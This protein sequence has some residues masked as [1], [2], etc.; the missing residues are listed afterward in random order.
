MVRAVTGTFDK[1]EPEPH[2]SGPAPKHWIRL[3]RSF[4]TTFIAVPYEKE[5]YRKNSTGTA[6]LHTL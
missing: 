1:L 4:S 3:F 6:D 5:F 2:K